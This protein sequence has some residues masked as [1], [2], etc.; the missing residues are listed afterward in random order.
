MKKISFIL[1]ALFT[2]A[3]SFSQTIVVGG[4]CIT[5]TITLTYVTDVD[6][7]PAYIGTGTVLGTADR[8]V[9]I[10]WIGSPE[11]VWVIAF[12]GQPYF[13]NTCNTA[14]PPGSSHN[15][16]SWQSVDGND[17]PGAT[18]L[19]VA[20]AVVLPVGITRFTATAI[21]AAVSLQWTT[22]QEINNRGFTIQRSLDGTVWTDLGFVAGNGNASNA[23]DYLFPDNFPAAGVNFYRLRQEDF[24][25][26]SSYSPVVTATVSSSNVF[27]LSDNPGR[28]MFQLKMP[29]STELLELL[30]TDATGRVVYKKQSTAGN[31]LVD[32]S[33]QAQG[34]YWLR[35]KKGTSETTLKLIKL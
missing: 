9:S 14:I 34:V 2:C 6:G 15:T 7:K 19:T 30:V 22:A 31:Q 8:E 3:I 13:S 10:Y 29:A 18:P 21:N 35:V 4:R 24:N 20:G 17:C 12:D 27:T 33:K 16:C 32:I 1:V 26:R 23:S 11:N 5:G 25:G 28:G